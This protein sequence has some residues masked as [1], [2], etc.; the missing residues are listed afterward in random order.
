M[1][2]AEGDPSQGLGEGRGGFAGGG[3]DDGSRSSRPSH[4]ALQESHS[5]G[6]QGAGSRA[7]GPEQVVA[8]AHDRN[9]GALKLR[10]LL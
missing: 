10:R 8:P 2:R 4:G 1:A 6:D 7:D 5:V 3:E 9:G